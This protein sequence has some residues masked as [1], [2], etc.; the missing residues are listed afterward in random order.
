VALMKVLKGS[1]LFIPHSLLGSSAIFKLK[2]G[3]SFRMKITSFS[4]E[5]HIEKDIELIYKGYDIEGLNITVDA[6]EIEQIIL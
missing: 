4:M 2:N 1:Q 3:V 5:A 6:E